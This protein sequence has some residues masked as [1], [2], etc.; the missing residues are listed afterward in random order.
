[1]AVRL[2]ARWCVAEVAEVAQ[3]IGVRGTVT[4]IDRRAAE[5]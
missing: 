5:A 2:Q 4:A 1:M 3:V